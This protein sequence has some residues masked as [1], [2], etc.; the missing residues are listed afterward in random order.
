MRWPIFCQ[1]KYLGSDMNR[2]NNDGYIRRRML[3]MELPGRRKWGRPKRWFMGAA[4]EDMAVVEL[5]VRL[6]W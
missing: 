2:G 4:R 6:F 5:C 3:R 1:L